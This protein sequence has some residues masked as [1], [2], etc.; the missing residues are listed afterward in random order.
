MDIQSLIGFTLESCRFSRGSYTFEFCGHIDGKYLALLVST[1]FGVSVAG[2][3]R[4]DVSAKFSQHMWPMLE[5][6]VIRIEL[7]EE[8]FEIRFDLGEGL[9]FTVFSEGPPD[10]NLLLVKNSSGDGWFPVL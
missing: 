2:Q 5:R 10:D 6:D 3:S 7:D 4:V 8:R 1:N 9:G